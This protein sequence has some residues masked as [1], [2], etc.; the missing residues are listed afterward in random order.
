MEEHIFLRHPRIP[1]L[2]TG[3]EWLQDK[4]YLSKTWN[5]Y[6]FTLLGFMGLDVLLPR[7]QEVREVTLLTLMA[8]DL[9]S[10]M[11]QPIR[12]WLVGMSYRDV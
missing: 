1:A 10:D 12:T 4:D 3:M 9:W 6:N 5:L 11:P 7:E 2:V 8:K